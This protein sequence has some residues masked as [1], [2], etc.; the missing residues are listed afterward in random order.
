MKHWKRILIGFA[1]AIVLA[2]NFIQTVKTHAEDY[3]ER[4][5]QEIEERINGMRQEC[6]FQFPHSIIER[7]KCYQNMM[8]N[9]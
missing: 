3:Q 6:R 8:A 1:I 9:V 5:N 4:R 7:A 2:V